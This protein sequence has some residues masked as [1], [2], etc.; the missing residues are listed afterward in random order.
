MKP[1]A[2]TVAI[3]FFLIAIILEIYSQ[4]VGGFTIFGSLAVI[5]FILVILI[6][7]SQN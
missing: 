2:R 6:L 4:V 7:I 1:L 3:I 5:G